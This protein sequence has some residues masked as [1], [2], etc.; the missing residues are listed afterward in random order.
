[1][2]GPPRTFWGKL[3]RD[4]VTNQV[5]AWHPLVDHCADV[6]AVCAALLELPTW[7]H[8]LARHAG[9]DDLDPVTVARLVVFAALHDLGKLNLGF[10]A[11]GRDDLGVPER[12]HVVEGFGILHKGSRAA[13]DALGGSVLDTWGAAACD[14]FEASIAH[15]GRPP[16]PTSI[17]FQHAWWTAGGGLDPLAG[18]RDLR[19]RTGYWAPRAFDA[20]GPELPDAPAFTHAFAGLVMLADWLGSDTRFFPYS[21]GLTD[22]PVARFST[23]LAAARK[24]LAVIGIAIEDARKEL[25]G[26]DRFNAVSR[27]VPNA[28]QRTVATQ[29]LP[30]TGSICVLESETGSGKTEE[31]AANR[32]EGRWRGPMARADG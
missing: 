12:G 14:L 2:K 30:E 20:G 22:E 23:A 17:D 18:L 29:P 25:T 28:A 8:R 5:V 1:M 31:L 7:R 3:E 13:L 32:N 9:R 27:L 26:R 15:H 21:E 19:E 4:P 16:D 24:A 11:K 6:A 10:Q